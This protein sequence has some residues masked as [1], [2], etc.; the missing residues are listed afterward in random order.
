MLLQEGN[1]ISQKMTVARIYPMSMEIGI[2]PRLAS[3]IGIIYECER[4]RVSWAI[5]LP[6]NQNVTQFEYQ[7]FSDNHNHQFGESDC[8]SIQCIII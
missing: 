1:E 8:L 4:I 6:H 3:A 5:E 2:F 7:K